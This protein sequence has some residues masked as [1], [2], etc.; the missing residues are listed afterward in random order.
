MELDPR[1]ARLQ[2]AASQEILR[3]LDEGLNNTW[4]HADATR[5]RVKTQQLEDEFLLT[6]EDNGRGFN[7]T[8]NGGGHGLNGMRERATLI[9][10]TLTVRSAPGDGTAVQLRV[11][12]SGGKP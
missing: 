5:I 7:L 2:P 6:I 3:I 9:G 10:G 8:R 1:S 12:T 11:P 4:K